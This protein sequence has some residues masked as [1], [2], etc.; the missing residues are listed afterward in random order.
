MYLKS[1][2]AYT[3]INFNSLYLNKMI[4]YHLNI[5]FNISFRKWIYFGQPNNNYSVKLL[6]LNNSNC[7]DNLTTKNLTN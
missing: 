3:N 6:K 7:F 4:K 5:K 1:N 2:Y